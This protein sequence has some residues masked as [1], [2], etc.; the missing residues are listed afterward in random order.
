MSSDTALYVVE[1]VP[2]LL[3]DTQASCQGSQW[4]LLDVVEA[5]GDLTPGPVT[6]P[7][8]WL[9]AFQGSSWTLRE[10]AKAPRGSS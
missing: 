5:V 10:V 4:K 6:R 2:G 7:S 1:G 8:T 9:R 3:L